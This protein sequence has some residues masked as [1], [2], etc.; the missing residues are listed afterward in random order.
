[1]RQYELGESFVDAVER[2]AGIHAIDPAW[3]SPD[4]LPT[5][6]ELSAPETWLARVDGVT[7]AL[8]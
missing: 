3:Q 4:L 7:L 5:V 1:M 2:E 8:R 6:D